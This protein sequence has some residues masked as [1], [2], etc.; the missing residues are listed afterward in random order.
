MCPSTA[1]HAEPSPKGR[2]NR[3]VINTALCTVQ[4]YDVYKG[5][6][7]FSK[8]R[9]TSLVMQ[10]RMAQ[11]RPPARDAMCAAEAA[12]REN[13]VVFFATAADKHVSM[14]SFTSICVPDLLQ[15]AAHS[16]RLD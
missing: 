10:V 4:A 8:K 6:S 1:N 16:H 9:P 2:C 13:E 7:R 15:H 3:L 5:N 14:Y 12:C 11:R